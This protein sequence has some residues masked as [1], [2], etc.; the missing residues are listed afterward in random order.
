[1]EGVHID[2]V[3]RRVI[4]GVPWRCQSLRFADGCPQ[5]HHRTCL[6]CATVCAGIQ[7]FQLLWP[8]EAETSW[9]AWAPRELT[10]RQF[11]D[12]GGSGGVGGHAFFDPALLPA[13]TILTYCCQV[14]CAD[15]RL[16]RVDEA[17]ELSCRRSGQAVAWMDSEA[18]EAGS[19]GTVEEKGV[20]WGEGAQ[21]SVEGIGVLGDLLHEASAHQRKEEIVAG[22][23][24]SRTCVDLAK[25]LTGHQQ[26]L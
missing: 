17:E 21:T 20:A 6:A 2:L 5:K 16:V 15:L 4:G 7:A 14:F 11:F 22:H 25:A 1:M 18:I 13:L 23:D 10:Q 12:C 3:V 8:G 26:C 19:A 24:C 9:D